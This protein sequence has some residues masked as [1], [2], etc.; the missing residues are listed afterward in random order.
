MCERQEHHTAPR[1]FTNHRS[2]Q[3]EHQPRDDTN[4]RN[5][6]RL[7]TRAASMDHRRHGVVGRWLPKA[8]TTPRCRDENRRL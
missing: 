2:L 7:E 3:A 4:P 1:R 5:D 6:V 8:P